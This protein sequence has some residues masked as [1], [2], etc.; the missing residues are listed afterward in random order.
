MT[1]GTDGHEGVPSHYG[2]LHARNACS[3]MTVKEDRLPDDIS[4]TSLAGYG[5]EIYARHHYTWA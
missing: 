4:G 5:P 2:L 3:S 1:A